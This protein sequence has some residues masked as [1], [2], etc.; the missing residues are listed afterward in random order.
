VAWCCK[1]VTAERSIRGQ[2]CGA[3][4]EGKTSL[5]MSVSVACFFFILGFTSQSTVSNVVRSR[6]SSFFLSFLHLYL[7]DVT[8]CGLAGRYPKMK[9]VCSSETLVPTCK[10][11][12]RRNSEDKHRHLH[13]LENLK[14]LI[15]SRVIIS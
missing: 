5:Q 10:S 11:T 1:T 14:S 2:L 3:K 9:A 7:L 6:L 13:R 8:P 15:C 4:R 12:R